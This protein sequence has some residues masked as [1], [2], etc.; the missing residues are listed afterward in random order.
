VV[1]G[2]TQLY[3]EPRCKLTKYIND[4]TVDRNPS[5]YYCNTANFCKWQ[6]GSKR[7]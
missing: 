7:K 1:K 2:E 5:Y 6:N 3:L 4:V